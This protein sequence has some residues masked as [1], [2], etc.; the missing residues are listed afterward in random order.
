MK[1]QVGIISLVM[2]F[3]IACGGGGSDSGGSCT[4]PAIAGSNWVGTKSFNASDTVLNFNLSFFADNTGK[5]G[6]NSSVTWSRAGNALSYTK[7]IEDA[8][9]FNNATIGCTTLTGTFE[10]RDI[11]DNSLLSS[12]TLLFNLIP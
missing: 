2:A 6:M 3:L 8:K 1:M 9:V 5:E 7:S 10:I 11:G 4:T 12:G